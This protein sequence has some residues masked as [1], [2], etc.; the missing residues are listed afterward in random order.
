MLRVL[1]LALLVISA[2]AVAADPVTGQWLTDTRDGIVE[3]AP[4][5]ARI[6]GRLVKTLVPIKGPAVDRNNPDPALRSRPIIGLPIL[7]GFVADGTVWRGIAYDPKVGKSY[8]TTLER[9]G[10][11]RLKVRGCLVAFLCKS[12]IWTK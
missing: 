8:K 4:C 6:C 5:G 2:P 9:L 12:V 10:P 11:D 7:T 1:P 3:I